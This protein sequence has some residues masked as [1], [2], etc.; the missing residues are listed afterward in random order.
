MATLGKINKKIDDLL[1][2]KKEMGDLK[3]KFDKD[4][5]ELKKY[6]K[7]MIEKNL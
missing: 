1:P 5:K 3:H 7:V 2:M 6:N 4:M